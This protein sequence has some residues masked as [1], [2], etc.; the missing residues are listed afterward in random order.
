MIKILIADD[1]GIVIE[2]LKFIIKKNFGTNCIM[3][4]AKQAVKY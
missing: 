1:E 3:E 2:S 4:S